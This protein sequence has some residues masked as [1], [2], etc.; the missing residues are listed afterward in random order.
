MKN[1]KRYNSERAFLFGVFSRYFDEK[2]SQ[3]KFRVNLK[4]LFVF[5]L[6]SFAL[7]WLASA[8]AVFCAFKYLRK[9]DGIS[10]ANVLA[11]PFSTAKYRV[12]MGEFQ[13]KKAE[14]YLKNK[15][16]QG[17]FMSLANGVARS[18]DNIEARILLAQMYYTFGRDADKAADVLD[19]KI[20]KAFAAKN[21]RYLLL[22]ISVFGM[23]DAYREK[24]AKLAAA[25]AD[26][27]II[28]LKDILKSLSSALRILSREKRY[29]LVYDYCRRL[30]SLAQNAE[31]KK[32]AA[33]N[34][35]VALNSDFQSEKAL[36]LLKEAD[37]VSGDIYATTLFL[38]LVGE[39]EEIRALNLI[40]AA[41]ARSSN[42]SDYY[43]MRA[44]L[45]GDFGDEEG[46]RE[47]RRLSILMSDDVAK[48]ALLTISESDATRTFELSKKFLKNFPDKILDLSLVAVK[49]GNMEI[50]D[51]CL[52]QKPAP[53]IE[54]ILKLEKAELYIVGQNPK[55]A[56]VMLDSIR[57]SDVAKRKNSGELFT[58]YD[59]AI[60]VLS[61]KSIDEELKN[62][63]SAPNRRLRDITLFASFLKRA[64]LD[65][66]AFLLVS[67]GLRKFPRNIRLSEIFCELALKKNDIAAIVEAGKNRKIRVPVKYMA[68]LGE[69]V[70]SDRMVFC[71][72]ADIA[73]ILKDSETAKMKIEKYKKIF[74]GF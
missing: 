7:F 33:R 72:G 44:M 63:V 39:G 48:P 3:W 1:V 43:E 22:S 13:I 40:N 68:K 10:F 35:A 9:Y 24:S 61:G 65:G 47:S 12:E 41:I 74:G 5:S 15:D 58:N 50:I 4:M 51:Y 67:E 26:S 17:A 11:M 52:S 20:S 62:F 14:E 32:F 29:D 57:F 42:K 49:T 59:L 54:F 70:K 36:K 73:G 37:I 27:E 25:C 45:T 64:N 28:P 31:L 21:K 38:N 6:A 55:D 53:H 46:E 19:L 30:M 2:E 56:Q 69:M 34:G 66:Q 18:P 23:S 8:V 16:I 71:D 60:K